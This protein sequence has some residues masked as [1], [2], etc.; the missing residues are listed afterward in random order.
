MLN[1]T[2]Q[3]LGDT[4]VVHC[5][6]SMVIGYAAILRE[7]ALTQTNI[8]TLVLDLARVDRIDACG[9]G[10]LLNI[11][12]WARSNA[13]RFKLMNVTK[14]V[15]H[16]LELTNLQSV[17][18]VCSVPDLLCLVHRAVSTTPAPSRVQLTPD[19]GALAVEKRARNSRPSQSAAPLPLESSPSCKQY[20][21]D[22]FDYCV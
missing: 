21:A 3:N 8:G 1:V 15:E 4:S 18:E 16:I 12:K 17:F 10:A 14:N 22:E 9:L 7:A 19:A 2:I 13:I 5:E 11:R 6:G 20:V